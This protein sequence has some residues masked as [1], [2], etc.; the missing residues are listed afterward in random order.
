MNTAINTKTRGLV[1]INKESDK[2]WNCSI[3]L[4]GEDK[5][6]K[7]VTLSTKQVISLLR[8][9]EAPAPVTQKDSHVVE[10]F[11]APKWVELKDFGFFVAG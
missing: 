1:Q 5:K 8:V 10:F 11:K 4:Y 3:V 2:V 9:L 7:S 6:L